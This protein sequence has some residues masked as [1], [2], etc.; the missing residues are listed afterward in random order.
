MTDNAQSTSMGEWKRPG[1]V[2]LGGDF[3]GLAIVRSLGRHGVPV[4]I[5]DDEYSIGRFSKYTTQTVRN[6]QFGQSACAMRKV[7]SIFFSIWEKAGPER[8]GPFP[9]TGRTCSGLLSP[10]GGAGR[11]ISRAHSGMGNNEMG[12]EQVEYLQPRA[13]TGYTHPPHLVSAKS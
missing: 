9:D 7:P 5:V 13:K 8:L 4:V 6:K 11:D 2:V 3:H 1:A 10:Q 12:L